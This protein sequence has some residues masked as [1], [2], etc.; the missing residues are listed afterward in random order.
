[1]FNL[2]LM[3]IG[4][5]PTFFILKQPWHLFT[6]ETHKK[7]KYN[8]Y[9]LWLITRA[10]GIDVN[11][12]Y[13]QFLFSYKKKPIQPKIKQRCQLCRGFSEKHTANF[14]SEAPLQIVRH[15][16]SFESDFETSTVASHF[17]SLALLCNVF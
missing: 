3:S 9:S 10:V 7:H 12:S 4:W 16:L 14:T 2:A 5:Q 13:R 15:T 1:M 6:P 17:C 11:L 8:N